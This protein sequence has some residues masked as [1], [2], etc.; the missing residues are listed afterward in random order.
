LGSSDD[1]L[2]ELLMKT[3]EIKRRQEEEQK[4]KEEEERQ[5]RKEENNK[6]N[7]DG[8]NDRPPIIIIPFFGG[9]GPTN[10]DPDNPDSNKFGGFG[11]FFRNPFA[12]KGPNEPIKGPKKKPQ[13]VRSGK[14]KIKRKRIDID[15]EIKTLDDLINVADKYED[16]EDL[17]YS[18][19]MTKLKAL[20]APLI[21]LREMIGLDDLKNQ[22]LVQVLFLLSGFQGADQMLH[23]VISGSSGCGK[24]S[25]AI[26]LSK[27]YQA[28]GYAN[29]KFKIVKRSDLIAGY[30]GQTALKTQRVIDEARGGV[31]F[32]DEAYSLGHETGRD[33]FSKE[34][35]DTLNQNLSERKTEFICI[36][37]GYKKELEECF[38]SANPGL[39][40]R[41]PFRYEIQDYDYQSLAAIFRKKV[42]LDEPNAGGLRWQLAEIPLDFFKE[43]EQYFTFQGGDMENLFQ[44]SKIAHTM[45]VFGKHQTEDMMLTYEDIQAGMKLFLKS[46]EVK[47][48]K[49]TKEE[50]KQDEERKK[51]RKELENRKID[52]E[53]EIY[54]RHK[55][56]DDK[57][58]D[59]KPPMYN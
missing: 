22:I 21:E 33:S 46:D 19:D 4:K 15:D 3:Q 53:H 17:E 5:K 55:E 24:T 36:I 9:G 11:D 37:A 30:C 34:A 7:N 25:F 45:R 6:A 44:L 35:I 2:L 47:N 38:F 32:I 48:R 14:K 59:E 56:L 31:L 41:F 10:N 23:T 58:N 43:N 16:K 28:L 18:F 20:R 54:K 40:R 50:R 42:E 51:K 57:F 12:N 26:I 52:E 27:I 29:G 49:D 39:N 1:E 13:P 8:G